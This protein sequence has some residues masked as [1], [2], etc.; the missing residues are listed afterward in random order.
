MCWY[1]FLMKLFRV[2]NNEL[3]KDA[4]GQLL[5]HFPESCQRRRQH[6]I[7]PGNARIAYINTCHYR[8]TRYTCGVVTC[9]CYLIL[10]F[11][12]ET[13]FVYKQSAHGLLLINV[14]LN[15]VFNSSIN[16]K[17]KLSAISKQHRDLYYF[18]WDFRCKY[19]GS[20]ITRPKQNLF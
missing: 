6:D 10:W 11:Q 4:A 15:N 7:L 2:F 1:S 9:P 5:S 8:K 18:N 19:M 13:E 14:I 16:Y 17:R 12:K 3:T 20:S